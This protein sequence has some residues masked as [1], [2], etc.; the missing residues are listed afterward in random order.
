MLS[1]LH[2]TRPFLRTNTEFFAANLRSYLQV[3]VHTHR[4][5]GPAISLS[6][7][8]LIENFLSPRNWNHTAHRN[9]QPHI[10]CVNTP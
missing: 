8:I 1:T 10:A 9:C 4:R 2:V 7:A 6:D 5:C 3:K